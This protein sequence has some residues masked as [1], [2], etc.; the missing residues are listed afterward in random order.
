ML[1]VGGGS[2]VVGDY[3][4]NHTRIHYQSLDLNPT[5]RPD[6]LGDVRQIPAAD[7]AFDLVAVFEVLEHLPFNDFEPTLVELKRVARHYVLLS[8][9]DARPH[10]RLSAKIPFFP[11]L[12][13]ALKLPWPRHHRPHP[14]HFW[15]VGERGFSNQRLVK[16]MG[17]HFKLREQFIPYENQSHHFYLLEKN[18]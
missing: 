12:Q 18:D 7:R 8:L 3:L 14:E 6:L 5:L 15:E 9:P 2:G 1:E 17:K 16:I 4:K 10:L 13:F 11:R